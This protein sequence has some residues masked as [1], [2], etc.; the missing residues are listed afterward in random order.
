MSESNI[1]NPLFELSEDEEEEID[2]HAKWFL[3]GASNIDE[4]IESL[5]MFERYLHIMKTHGWELKKPVDVDQHCSLVRT[6]KKPVLSYPVDVEL[7]V[8]LA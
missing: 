7:E 3:N 5:R 2:L 8:D 4:C 1:E 6:I